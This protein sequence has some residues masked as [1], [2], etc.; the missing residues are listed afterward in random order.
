M[1]TEPARP[2]GASRL[3]HLW[4]S[5]PLL[6]Q[7]G[8]VAVGLMV[9]GLGSFAYLT[10]TGR[11]LGPTDF[12]PVATLWVLFNGA[13]LALFQPIE[14]EV[15]RATAARRAVGQGAGPVLL[16]AVVYGMTVTAVFAVL[17]LVTADVLTRRVFN[18][19]GVLVPLL[20]LGFVGLAA[21]HTLR[22]VFGGNE[23]FTR[24]GL[25]L[26]VD[27]ALRVLG[28][29]LLAITATTGV[30]AFGLALVLAPLLAAALTTGRIGPLSR[31]GPPLAWRDF[32]PPLMVL[33]GAALLS[34]LIVN[35][36]PIAAQVLARPDEAETAGIFIAALVLT[37]IPLFFFGA[38]QAA[39]LPAL[40]RLAATGQAAAF[41][42]QLRQ[43]IVLVCAVAALFILVMAAIGPFVLRLLYGS[44]FV[45][46]RAVLVPLA[47]AAA[48]YMVAQVMAQTL[49]ALRSYRAALIGWG[50]GSVVFMLCLLVP[51]EL[52]VRVGTAFL[53]G[54]LSA[55]VILT[56]FVRTGRQSLVETEVPA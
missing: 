3:V 17:A 4:R 48:L 37:R 55:L 51:S 18:G 45:A 28:P 23:K 7:L 31:P 15:S 2:G 21:E 35:A 36:A 11:A 47:V 33:T 16:K 53:A 12:A 1:P 29:V 30:G 19:A 13:G 49:I 42:R 41:G 46:T 27:G 56:L 26:G 50:V 10:V 32:A 9:L 14:Q 44:E 54:S 52:Q 20:V 38:V 43:V 24:Y 40:A 34:Q 6:G 25:Q 5:V 8:P 22:G 39:F